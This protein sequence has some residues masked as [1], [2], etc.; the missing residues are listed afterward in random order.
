MQGLG[1]LTFLAK[2]CGH[3]NVS[4]E[5]KSKPLLT[6]RPWIQS[7]RYDTLSFG[8]PS[9]VFHNRRVC[10]VSAVHR[11]VTICKKLFTK[12]FTFFRS[13][14]PDARCPDNNYLEIYSISLFL[15]AFLCCRRSLVIVICQM[16]VCLSYNIFFFQLCNR[17]IR[18]FWLS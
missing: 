1:Y 16:S 2:I 7:S 11:N 3:A 4:S 5:I 18:G 6:K 10:S 17:Y 14:A 15:F 9:L 13:W 8:T 12:P